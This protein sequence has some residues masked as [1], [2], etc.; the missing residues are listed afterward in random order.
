[1]QIQHDE[2]GWRLSLTAPEAD[3]P[4]PAIGCGGIVLGFVCGVSA[5]QSLP[6]LAAWLG[7][8]GDAW[9]ALLGVGLPLVVFVG[10]FGALAVVTLLG[11]RGLRL[12]DVD[13]GAGTLRAVERAAFGW[14]GRD[15]TFALERLEEISV[16]L[17]RRRRA[18]DAGRALRVVLRVR[19]EQAPLGSRAGWRECEIALAVDGLERNDEVAD[20]A[21]RL[22]AAAGLTAFRVVR[23]DVRDVELLLGHGVAAGLTALPAPSQP[24]DYARDRVA[25]AARD[26]VKREI[27]PP[28]EPASFDGRPPLR[29]WSPGRRVAFHKAW[30]V[31]LTLAGLPLL[32]LPLLGLALL[33]GWGEAEGSRVVG[34]LVVMALTLPLGIAGVLMVAFS[35]P[36]SASLDWTRGAFVKR[37]L[38]R[39]E[40]WALGELLAVE[41]RGE[42]QR[43]KPKNGRAYFSYVC[44]IDVWYRNATGGSDRSELVATRP[45][46]DDPDTPWREAL[47][48]A[49]DL[50]RA[51]GIER[52][53]V[54]FKRA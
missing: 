30:K 50:A 6:D 47:P 54:D 20:F 23:Q 12:L 4:L 44:R 3:S 18:T 40:R 1:M 53:L 27:V 35:L 41:L 8:A 5:L 17:A 43:H 11:S 28:F 9:A 46:K 25:Q 45:Y 37:A 48:L 13:R 26:A 52:R 33:L 49:T 10:L 29:E 19:P 21:L 34:A 7:G 31:W 36:R 16:G 24:A 14:F 2:P 51:L 42:S 32:A 38:W 15:R 39:R 22:G